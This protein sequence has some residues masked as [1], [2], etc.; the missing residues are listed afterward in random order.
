MDKYD[1]APDVVSNATKLS[2]SDVQKRYDAVRDNKGEFSNYVPQR[3]TFDTVFTNWNELHKERFGTYLNLARTTEADLTAQVKE[4]ND[5]L[6]KQQADWDKTYGNTATAQK[7]KTN[8]PPTWNNIYATWTEELKK[9]FNIDT[10]NR[11]W[12]AD[13]DAIRQKQDLDKAYVAALN[14]YNAKNGT[15]IRPDPAVLGEI[16]DVNAATLVLYQV[17]FN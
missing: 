16:H 13:P 6:A 15:N 4:L 1:V 2:L 12:N 7:L 5:T 17:A 14:D 8:P 9:V 10:M 11:P 3:P